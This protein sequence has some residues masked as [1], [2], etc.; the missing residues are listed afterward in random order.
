[1]VV[2]FRFGDINRVV[3]EAQRSFHEFILP[4]RWIQLGLVQRAYTLLPIGRGSNPTN[5]LHAQHVRMDL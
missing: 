4:L 2:D 5:C 1:M 3:K